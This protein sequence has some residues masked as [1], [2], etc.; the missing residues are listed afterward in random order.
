MSYKRTTVKECM[1]K[2]MLEGKE[3]LNTLKVPLRDG[4]TGEAEPDTKKLLRELLTLVVKRYIYTFRQTTL[5]W[6]LLAIRIGG[7]IQSTFV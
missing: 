3:L 2:G 4:V 7:W 5:L 6:V 1:D